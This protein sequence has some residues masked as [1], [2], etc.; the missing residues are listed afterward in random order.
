VQPS[1]FEGSGLK[2]VFNR[3]EYDK[4]SN[5]A[6][7]YGPRFKWTVIDET[8]TERFVSPGAHTLIRGIENK[9]SQKPKGTDVKLH[10]WKEGPGTQPY[11][12]EY[13]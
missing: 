1:E 10:I 4:D 8:G 9:M 2:L 7:K 6:K 11:K 13:A 5:Y 3:R 12:V